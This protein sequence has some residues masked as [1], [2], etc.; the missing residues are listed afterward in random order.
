MLFNRGRLRAKVTYEQ[1]RDYPSTGGQATLRVSIRSEKAEQFLERLLQELGWHGPCQADF[2]IDSQ[3]GTP[4]LIDLNPR[5]WGSL[6]QAIASGV[7]FP[8]LIYRI[9][10]DGDVEPVT[11]FRTGVVTRW[12]GG[13]LAALPSRLRRSDQKLET[14]RNFIFPST[15]AALYD[16]LSASDPF[17]FLTWGL[18]ALYRA[19]RFRSLTAVSHESLDGIWE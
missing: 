1:L 13:D 19:L 17:P 3:D 16:D 5:L 9:A 14:L 6:A 7:D 15:R 10:R 2:I 12:L 4:Y 11:S 8:A 18:D